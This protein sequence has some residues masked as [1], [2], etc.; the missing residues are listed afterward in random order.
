MSLTSLRSRYLLEPRLEFVERQKL[1]FGSKQRRAERRLVVGHDDFE[2]RVVQIAV[3]LAV[4]GQH[5]GHGLLI[6]F[7]KGLHQTDAL[8][9]HFVR[10]LHDHRIDVARGDLLDGDRLGI[11]DHDRVVLANAQFLHHVGDGRRIVR[12]DADER[13]QLAFVVLDGVADVFA[14]AGRSMSSAIV[15]SD[16][17]FGPAPSLNPL[18]RSIAF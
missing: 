15:S 12:P 3:R 7:V 8:I 10:V 2:A 1:G 16:W 4:M 18:I 13:R 14:R 17:N 5:C 9:A 11:E 6:V